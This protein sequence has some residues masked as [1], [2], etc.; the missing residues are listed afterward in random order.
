MKLKYFLRLVMIILL[1]VSSINVFA[2]DDLFGLQLNVK[3][4]S[5]RD[6]ILSADIFI[7]IYDNLTDGKLVYNSTDDFLGNVTEVK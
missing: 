6:P 2:I 1:S 5:S 3:N 4:Q 7:E